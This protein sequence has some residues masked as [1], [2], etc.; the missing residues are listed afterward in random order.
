MLAKRIIPCL[1]VVGERVVKGTG[2]RNLQVAGDPVRLGSRYAREGAD[3]LVY[4]DI[5]ATK[6]RRKVRS[7]MVRQIAEHLEIPFTVGGGI[8]HPRDVAVLLNSGADKVTV[9]SAALTHPPL[10]DLLS[11]E[12]GSQCLVVAIDA[13]RSGRGWH[14]FIRGGTMD[15]GRDAVDWAREAFNRGAGEILLTSIDR[16][17]RCSGYDLMLTREVVAVV[18][19]PV[20]A[21]GGGGR[22]EHFF[23]VFYRAGADAALA[24]RIFHYRRDNIRSLKNYLDKR[25]IP[26]RI[27]WSPDRES[28]P[29]HK[30]KGNG[31]T[32]AKPE[33]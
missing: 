17:G 20:I 32:A 24:A 5:A 12:F 1:D 29:G 9:N 16:D 15:T 10:I 14:V 7:R 2:F 27:P 11:R 13:A 26:V 25:S 4:L 6:R 22:R 33:I 8:D 18:N 19:C 31:G 23:D 21:S 28:P 3:E 30:E